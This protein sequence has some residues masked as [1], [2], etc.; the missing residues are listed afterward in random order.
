MGGNGQN[1]CDF[2]KSAPDIALIALAA[3]L[4]LPPLIR[5]NFYLLAYAWIW[6][7]RSRFDKQ[8]LKVGS[9]LFA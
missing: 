9:C 6:A 1:Q 7:S 8:I 2:G 5:L 3:H 4:F